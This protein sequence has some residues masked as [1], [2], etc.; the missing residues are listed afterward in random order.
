MEE[1]MPVAE[2]VV[3]GGERRNYEDDVPDDATVEKHVSEEVKMEDEDNLFDDYEGY[4]AK[5][6]EERNRQSRKR[7]EFGGM[8]QRKRKGGEE[9]DKSGVLKE[10]N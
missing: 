9:T 10:R 6:E 4:D 2:P 1:E 7:K 8:V 3:G 5:E